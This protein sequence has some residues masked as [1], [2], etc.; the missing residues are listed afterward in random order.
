VHRQ[1][2]DATVQ[3]ILKVTA[4][5]FFKSERGF[6]GEFY[7]QL[8]A[9]LQRE[10]ILQEDL[11]LE[12]EYQKGDRHGTHQRPDIILHVPAEYRN[13]DV[14]E[15]N[16]AIWALKRRASTQDAVDDFGKVNTMFE[17]LRYSLG[18][19]INIDSQHTRMSAYTGS[20]PDRIYAIAVH[21]TEEGVQL[22]T[23]RPA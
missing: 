23:A 2:I 4:P 12:M 14:R 22:R 11:L 16:I 3:A 15:N 18:F 9:E 20:F 1:I 19:F 6:Q 17:A 8:R 5:R 13:A 21:L 10:T 7:C